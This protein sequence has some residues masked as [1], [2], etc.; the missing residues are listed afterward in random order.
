MG[1]VEFTTRFGLIPKQ[2]STMFSINTSTIGKS[3]LYPS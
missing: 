1:I 2:P 3:E